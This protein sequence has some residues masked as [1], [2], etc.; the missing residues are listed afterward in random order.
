[1]GRQISQIFLSLSFGLNGFLSVV[2]V[3]PEL[4][5]MM[6]FMFFLLSLSFSSFK[7]IIVIRREERN[8]NLNVDF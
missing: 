4:L 3:S 2:L 6:I 7:E 8:G 1:M 5:M